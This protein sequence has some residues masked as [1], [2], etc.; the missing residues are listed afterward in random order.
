MTSEVTIKCQWNR[1]GAPAQ[2]HVR[3]GNR[4]FGTDEIMPSPAQNFTVLHRNLCDEHLDQVKAQYLEVI[5]FDL[6]N[7]RS[8]GPR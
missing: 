7:C 1:C 4:T 6:G 5:V 3:F 8:C 2:R